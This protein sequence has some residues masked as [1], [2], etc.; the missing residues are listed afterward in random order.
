MSSNQNTYLNNLITS[1]TP[2]Q[3][4]WAK[5]ELAKAPATTP[6]VSPTTPI[7]TSTPSSSGGS[8]N[9]SSSNKSYSSTNYS[10]MYQNNLDFK[11]MIDHGG[12]A[13]QNPNGTWGVS[14]SP[15]ATQTGVTSAD[16]WTSQNGQSYND[17]YKGI[18][19]DFAPDGSIYNIDD[20][21]KMQAI[22]NAVNAIQGAGGSVPQQTLDALKGFNGVQ[23]YAVPNQQPS[24]LNNNGNVLD[25][26]A[27]LDSINNLIGKITKGT[28]EQT[29][30]TQKPLVYTPPATNQTEDTSAINTR[31]V[32]GLDGN[33]YNL[34]DG[35][36][37]D[38]NVTNA[39]GRAT[40]NMLTY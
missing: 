15:G 23:Q 1:G 34:N 11:D 32:Q 18:S 26:D 2:G 35:W 37:D 29:Q 12:V 28:D 13:Y 8:S 21:S 27:F 19:W 24:Y 39:F 31:K 30:N 33:K 7:N 16:G 20:G 4:A 22:Q 6:T 25:F 40:G 3:A 9:S 5:A 14:R 10:D 36:N 38:K 17:Q